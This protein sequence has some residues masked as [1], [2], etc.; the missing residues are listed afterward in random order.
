[1]GRALNRRQCRPGS[2]EALAE[3]LV[4]GPAEVTD[5]DSFSY[6]VLCITQAVEIVLPQSPLLPP[7]VTGKCSIRPVVAALANPV[8][9]ASSKAAPGH[10]MEGEHG[11]FH[12][13]GMPAKRRLVK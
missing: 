1:L 10:A 5:T 7:A 11:G 6:P 9:D 13:S 3:Y 8:S 12:R 4:F 2:S